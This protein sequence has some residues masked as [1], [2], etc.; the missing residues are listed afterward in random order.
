MANIKPAFPMNCW[1]F[2]IWETI[3]FNGDN[4]SKDLGELQVVSMIGF[5]L[6]GMLWLMGHNKGNLV[7]TSES[8]I[9]K[10]PFKVNRQLRNTVCPISERHSPFLGSISGCQVNDFTQSLI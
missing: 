2:P 9:I 1:F 6:C 5:Y 3:Q 4:R 8:L 7:S 10:S